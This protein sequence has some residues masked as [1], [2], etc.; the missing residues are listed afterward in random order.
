M[1]LKEVKKYTGVALGIMLLILIRVFEN[2]LFYDPL[3]SF[4]KKEYQNQVL[5]EL[6]QV[7]YFLNITF[8]Y[9]LNSFITLF[10][11]YFLFQKISYVKL[12]FI[13]L[14]VFYIILIVLLFV[15]L[16]WIEKTNYMYLFYVR[17]FLIQPI[18]LLLF[19]PA[20]YFQKNN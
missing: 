11:V 8:R 3:L 5:P 2:E 18:F 20:F 17:R 1:K 14:I 16:N 19:I 9:F 12:S 13:L 4:F 15:Q 6:N 10:I 7:D